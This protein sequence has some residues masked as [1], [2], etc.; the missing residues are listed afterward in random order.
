MIALTPAIFVQSDV[1]SLS[2]PGTGPC[3][4]SVDLA[5]INPRHHTVAVSSTKIDSFPFLH[6]V[7][8]ACVAFQR[9]VPRGKPITAAVP[10]R[11]CSAA[12][13]E[14][15]TTLDAVGSVCSAAY[16]SQV[17][18][19]MVGKSISVQGKIG[20]LLAQAIFAHY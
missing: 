8:G 1:Q 18:V 19:G 15:G 14:V 20:R 7:Y 10:R 17:D 3:R 5:A 9:R 2:F 4:H 13:I 11:V 12:R 16:C 6:G